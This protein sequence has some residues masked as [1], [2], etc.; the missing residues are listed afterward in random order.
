MA[1]T[2][3]VVDLEVLG[4]H[5]WM[6]H[7]GIPSSVAIH[8]MPSK[9]VVP[10]I[11]QHHARPLVH[12]TTDPWAMRAVDRPV[13]MGHIPLPEPLDLVHVVAIDTGAGTFDDGGR[14]TGVL[15]PERRFVIV[16]KTGSVRGR[17]PLP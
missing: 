10:W 9:D 12:D 16:D 5:H 15:L 14:L 11:A 3:L 17:S 1:T 8:E 13:I 6:I 4:E 7:A 2:T